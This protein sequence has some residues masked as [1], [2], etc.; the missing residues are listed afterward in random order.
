MALV[1]LA[2]ALI[3]VGVAAVVAFQL[4]RGE[5]RRA[6][7]FSASLAL[8]GSMTDGE[9]ALVRSEL[10]RELAT[11]RRGS[12]AADAAL[13]RVFAAALGIGVVGVVG[14]LVQPRAAALLETNEPGQ[15]SSHSGAFAAG[16]LDMPRLGLLGLGG[17]LVTGLV[18][19]IVIW[20]CVR[21]RHASLE[22][23]RR[24]LER[25]GLLDRRRESR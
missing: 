14:L 5:R 17:G 9:R 25:A 3:S 11:A 24:L 19:G 15:A 4:G 10:V 8:L 23:Q 12:K 13:V 21:A 6:E 20:V 16:A 1:A 22:R 7:R 18:S 2:F